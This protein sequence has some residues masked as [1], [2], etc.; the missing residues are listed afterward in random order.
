LAVEALTET[1]VHHQVLAGPVVVE[2]ITMQEQGLAV[3]LTKAVQGAALGVVLVLAMPLNLEALG[4]LYLVRLAGVA[5]E[6]Q[7]KALLELL[8]LL[9]DLVAAEVVGVAQRRLVL[10]VLVV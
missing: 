7:P 9:V 6:L 1:Q 5:R 2:L 3:A 8:G 10:V 4:V